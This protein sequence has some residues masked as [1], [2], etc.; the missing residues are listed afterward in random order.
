MENKSIGTVSNYYGGLH[1]MEKDGE[2]YWVIEDWQTDL[3][4]L[5]HWEKCDK[6]LYDALVAYEERRQK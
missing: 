5:S 2:Y 3:S 1:V 6:E 4:D